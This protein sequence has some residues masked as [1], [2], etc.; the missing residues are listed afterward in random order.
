M[1]GCSV[2]AENAVEAVYVSTTN[3]AKAAEHAPR[4]STVCMEKDG[5]YVSSAEVALFAPTKNAKIYANYVAEIASVC[6][7]VLARGASIVLVGIFAYMGVG[8]SFASNAV[9]MVSAFI[10]KENRAAENVAG[11]IYVNMENINTFVGNATACLFANTGA[12][13][14]RAN[15]AKVNRYACITKSETIASTVYPWDNLLDAKTIAWYVAIKFQKGARVL[16]CVPV[17]DVIVQS[18]SAPK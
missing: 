3:S 4:N 15:H 14:I 13:R 1:E 10:K 11:A 17:Q 9:G 6:T 16:D 12:A 7:D 8:V 18:R 2:D 5:Q